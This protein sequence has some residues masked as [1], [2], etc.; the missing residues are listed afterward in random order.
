MDDVG[1]VGG[2]LG[3]G[4][5]NKKGQLSRSS[6]VYLGLWWGCQCLVT[7]DPRESGSRLATTL[8]SLH[9]VTPSAILFIFLSKAL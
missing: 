4:T 2:L 6:C 1:N 5:R 3:E 7:P 8:V 9:G